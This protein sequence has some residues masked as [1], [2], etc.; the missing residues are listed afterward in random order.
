M[1]RAETVYVEVQM[2]DGRKT[3]F[4]GKRKMLKESIHLEDG[5]LQVRLDFVNGET[6]IFTLPDALMAK[7]ATHGAEQK[8]GDEV[9]GLDDVEDMVMAVDTLI[10]RLA[11]G[12]WAVKREANSMAGTSILAKALVEISGKPIQVIKD[13]LGTKSQAEKV[14]M[15][16][17]ASILPTIQ[18]LEA[19]K[20]K[21]K[22]KSDI[23]TDALLSELV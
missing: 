15:R 23:D 18:R 16:Q 6:R 7:F 13:F 5:P 11:A 12:E 2:D 4:A 3:E 14:A 21:S 8:I 19:E 22:K 9:A 20:S 17:N 10:D 1:A